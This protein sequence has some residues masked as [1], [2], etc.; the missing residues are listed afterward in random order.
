M[1]LPE[2]YSS[3]GPITDT[4][5]SLGQG[6]DVGKQ[7]DGRKIQDGN[8]GSHRGLFSN[9]RNVKVFHELN[10]KVNTGNGQGAFKGVRVIKI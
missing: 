5:C 10:L 9:M 3:T 1:D 4:F 7:H 2:E 6:K 8:Q